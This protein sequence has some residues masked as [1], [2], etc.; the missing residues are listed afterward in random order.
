LKVSVRI[1]IGFL[2]VLFLT[3]MVAMVGW[4]ALVQS[5][6]GFGTERVG[7]DALVV[8]GRTDKAELLGRADDGDGAAAAVRDGLAAIERDLAAL[9]DNPKLADQVHVARQAVSLY[10][11]NYATFQDSS[12]TVDQSAAAILALGDELKAIVVAEVARRN[13]RLEQARENVRTA[14]EDRNRADSLRDR[15]RAMDDALAALSLAFERSLSENTE[16]RFQA[17]SQALDTV[18]PITAGLASAVTTVDAV[19]TADLNRAFAVAQKSLKAFATASQHART[20]MAQR[21]DVARRLND[22]AQSL[23]EAMTVL[24]EIH[25]RHIKHAEET[26][27]PRAELVRL[28]EATLALADLESLAARVRSAEQTFVMTGDEGAAEVADEAARKLLA[29]ALALRRASGEGEAAA[30]AEAIA[31][32]AQAQR[33]ALKEVFD[34]DDALI[35]AREARRIHEQE[36]SAGLAVLRALTDRASVAA[37]TIS[38]Q[39]LTATIRSFTSLD[40]A[41]NTIAAAGNLKDATQNALQMIFAYISQP[42]SQDVGAIRATLKRIDAS[43]KGLIDSVVLTD[44]WNV[45]DLTAAFGDRVETLIQEFERLVTE[46]N[47]IIMADGGMAAAREA[48]TSALERANAAA[49][50]ASDRASTLARTL[51]IVGGG[52]AL[53]LGIAAAWGIGRSISRPVAAITQ[54]MKRLADND[55]TVD[56]PG[57]DRKDEIGD[58]AAAVEVFKKNSVKIE[59]LQAEQTAQARRNARRV[60]T[61]MMALTN[62]LDEEVRAAVAIV[63]EQAH[64]MHDAAVQMTK[65]VTLTE[66]RSD[67][68]AEASRDAA[69]N[70]DSVAAAAEEMSGSIQ[71]ISRQVS[72]ASDIAHRAARQAETTNARI[73]GLA[74]AAN[75]IGEV[76]N[77]ISDIAK[78]TNLLALNATIEAARA[79]EAG[80]GFAVVANEVKTLA[81]QTAK[82]TEDIATEI[83]S[84]QSATREAV[85]AIEGIV[86]VIGEI[87]EITAAVSAAVE[88]QTAST[89]EISQSAQH[90]ARSTQ[91]A[92]DNIA[93]V[94]SSAELTGERAREV[95]DAAQEVR[96]CVQH[97]L[98]ALER[99]IRSGSEEDRD[100]HALRS[101][102]VGVTVDLGDGAVRPCLM[103]ELAPSG[104][105]TLDRSVEGERGR[106]ITVDVPD[107]GR[108]QATLVASTEQATHIRLDIPESRLGAM[109]AFIAAR[110]SVRAK[111]A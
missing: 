14:N 39:S 36:V 70:V 7:L 48:L 63:H 2:F 50:G 13:K 65:S 86:T 83:G 12:R 24:K 72:G 102:N 99:I 47:E 22:S 61:E 45:G 58:M 26:V 111:A 92:S 52:L 84:M 82:A 75:Q 109:R 44:P 49:A 18:L 51:L 3:V 76:V 73:Q 41:Q 100:M 21:T 42:L 106:D 54:A 96:N 64:V 53:V 16:D 46:T 77:L 30:P 23:A 98:E 29:G 85:E 1:L 17:L 33:Q 35:A 94:L 9:A 57:R 93:E 103:Q 88:Q 4:R 25:V 10:R 55:L 69:G 101:V 67:A 78:Q 19:D 40:A 97:M 8:L 104:V 89:G 11:D 81:N 62:A 107:L 31:D 108:M 66:Q 74:K 5:D 87:N 60:K 90:G 6:R 91:D 37:D 80:K 68:A 20:A 105:A 56:V 27:A 15:V 79:G 43:K 28:N 32:A 110:D 71:E 38:Q 34:L 95:Q 59:Q